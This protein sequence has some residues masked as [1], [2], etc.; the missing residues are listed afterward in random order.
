MH[1]ND[2]QCSTSTILA[3]PPTLSFATFLRT[4]AGS[5]SSPPPK[6]ALEPPPAP[7]T[8]TVAV[9]PTRL[10]WPAGGD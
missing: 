10:W 7:P 8:P 5:P 9:L 3:V 6:P 2:A 4:F 1:T